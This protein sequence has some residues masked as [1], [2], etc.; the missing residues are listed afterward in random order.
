MY[1]IN[2]RIIPLKYTQIVESLALSSIGAAIIK[3]KWMDWIEIG[4]EIEMGLVSQAGFDEVIIS[5]RG[6]SAY[7]S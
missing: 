5:D 1:S 3:G 2:K 6:N 4:V 7:I